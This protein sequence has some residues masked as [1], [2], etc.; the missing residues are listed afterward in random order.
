MKKLCIMM[1]ILVS[2]L[3]ITGCD[4][5]ETKDGVTVVKMSLKVFLLRPQSAF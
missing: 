3:G 2:L 1:L 5:D 4:N